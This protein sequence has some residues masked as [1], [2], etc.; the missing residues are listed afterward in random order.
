MKQR[1]DI[2]YAYYEM[3]KEIASYRNESVEEAIEFC[4]V[5]KYDDMVADI[6]NQTICDGVD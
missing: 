4:I 1:I 3:V 5:E 2:D 6:R